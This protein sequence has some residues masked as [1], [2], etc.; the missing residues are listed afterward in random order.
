MTHRRMSIPEVDPRRSLPRP[1]RAH[2]A[3]METLFVIILIVAIGLLAQVAGT[4]SRGFDL[5]QAA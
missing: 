2:D 1:P 4:D 5:G 3:A